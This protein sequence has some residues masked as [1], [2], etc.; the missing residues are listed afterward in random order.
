MALVSLLSAAQSWEELSSWSLAHA[1]DHDEIDIALIA[2]GKVAFP[3]SVPLDPL[4]PIENMI[5][6]LFRHQLKHTEM[7]DA[8]G[9]STSDLTSF[10][11]SNPESIAA[12]IGS[13]FSEHNDIHEA[14]GI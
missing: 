7:D 1:L 3:L 8:L 12:F 5:D 4:P 14:L 6:W 2:H 9:V 10:D 11:F 13:N